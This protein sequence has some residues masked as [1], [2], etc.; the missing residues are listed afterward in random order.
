MSSHSDNGS[1]HPSSSTVRVN[2]VVSSADAGSDSIDA[3]PPVPETVPDPDILAVPD[4]PASSSSSTDVSPRTSPIPGNPTLTTSLR[5]EPR[6]RRESRPP[7]HVHYALSVDTSVGDPQLIQSAG[8]RSPP[9]MFRSHAPDAGGCTPVRHRLTR[10]ATFT[11]VANFENFK[12]EGRAGWKPATEPG[13]D[14][15]L[16]DG[17][18]EDEAPIHAECDIQVVDF[19]HDH[20]VMHHLNNTTLKPFL[21]NSKP[22]WVVCRWINVDGLSW[23]VIQALGQAKKLHKLALEDVVDTKTRTK[24]DWYSNHAFLILTLQ[25]LVHTIEDEHSSLDSDL[26]SSGGGDDCEEE[27]EHQFHDDENGGHLH[28]HANKVKPPSRGSGDRQSMRSKSSARSIRRLGRTMTRMFGIDRLGNRVDS[29]RSKSASSG[30][31]L[32]GKSTN[33]TGSGSTASLRYRTLHSYHANPNEARNKFMERH[34]ALSARDYAISAEQVSIFITADNTIISFFETSG[35][36]LQQPIIQRLSCPDTVLRQCCDASMVAQAL[37][38]AIIDLAMPVAALYS[39]VIGDL[40][41]D[42]LTKPD[43]K[44]TKMLYI[45]TTEISKVIQFITPI[46]KLIITLREHQTRLPPAEA[47]KYL[48]DPTKGV[49]ITPTTSVYLS[50]VYDHCTMINDQLIQVEKSAAG[51][52][53][54]IFNTVAANQNDTIKVL[55]NVTIAFLP[56]T[57]IV[58]YFGQN[59]EPFDALSEG[60]TYL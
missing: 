54:L 26:D 32:V 40:E 59:F 57:F 20:L 39:D 55:T 56:L 47:M 41:L 5:S 58:G 48:Q 8:P 50:D 49:I 35:E 45:M 10:S 4:V 9:D 3:F 13:L 1:G 11:P 12:V 25:K 6:L 16:P 42:I 15:S 24:A 22:K 14:P 19:S 2:P 17:G 51:L 38:D 34:S 44:H 29:A 52:I 21:K 30:K 31:I 53:H 23:D 46:S 28:V 7:V 60:I 43:M 18:R 27:E 36:D 37:I 33:S